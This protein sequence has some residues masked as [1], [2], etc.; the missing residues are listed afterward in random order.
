MITN[1][2]YD[3]ATE[4]LVYIAGPLSGDG[5]A[6]LDNVRE[7]LMASADIQSLSSPEF[8][9]FTLV[10]HLCVFEHILHPRPRKTWIRQSLVILSKCDLVFRMSGV[11]AGADTEVEFA[12]ECGIPVCYRMTE[13]IPLLRKRFETPLSK[14]DTNGE[15]QI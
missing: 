9:V 4:A 7:A 10:P 2:P 11:S 15:E 6:L 1:A 5:E 8:S 3:E 14:E 13:I 12:H